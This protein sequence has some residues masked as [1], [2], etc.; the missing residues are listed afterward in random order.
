MSKVRSRFW[1]VLLL[2]LGILIGLILLPGITAIKKTRSLSEQFRQI[3]SQY[4]QNIQVLNEINGRLYSVSLTVRAFLLDSSPEAN[5]DYQ[6]RF[7]ENRE[8]LDQKVS[9]L[10]KTIRPE[11]LHILDTIASRMNAYWVTVREVLEWTPQQKEERAT[12]YLREQQRPHREEIQEITENLVKLTR[13]NYHQHFENIDESQKEIRS[14]ME[15][16]IWLAVFLGVLVTIGSVVRIWQL[17]Q[18]MAGHQTRLEHL[19][20]DL[21][22]AQEEERRMISRELH[23]EIGQ[24]VTGLKMELTA[25]DQLRTSDP[26]GFSAH[27]AEAK[28]LAERTLRTIRSLATGLRPSVMDL[29]LAP[30]VQSLVRDISLRGS[31]DIQVKTSGDLDSV[32]E[33]YSVCIYRVIQEALTNCVRHAK[34]SQVNV[35]IHRI[36]HMISFEVTDN[37]TGLIDRKNEGFGLAGI[38]ERIR[39]LG[40]SVEIK[41][42]PGSGTVLKGMLVIP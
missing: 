26:S 23:D 21:I 2:A 1:L 35:S 25:L 14:E 30:A 39:E 22:R 36:S 38:E 6:T 15:N 29:G 5:S 34:A 31:T 37:G 3:Q 20:S 16:S 42:T 13:I 24:M 32:P 41:G 19:S 8:V 11:D 17:E 40:G 33:H 7:E 28:G 18:K 4:D 10:R 27:L 9:Q 12:F